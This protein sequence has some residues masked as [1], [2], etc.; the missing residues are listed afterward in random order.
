MPCRLGIRRAIRSPTRKRSPYEY[1]SQKQ[2]PYESQ[3]R[4]PYEYESQKW[5]P[6]EYE[7]RKQ[8]P[9]ESRRLIRSRTRRYSRT[10]PGRRCSVLRR[11]HP[12]RTLQAASQLP[13]APRAPSW[14]SSLLLLPPPRSQDRTP[15]QREYWYPESIYK[16]DLT[17]RGCRLRVASWVARD[18]GCG[19]DRRTALP[20]PSCRSFRVQEKRPSPR[21]RPSSGTPGSAKKKPPPSGRMYS[22]NGSPVRR[23]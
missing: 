22:S 3:K 17:A 18:P 12:F 20:R 6:Y 14:G 23:S 9:Y 1:E 2:N 4:N 5:N 16:G 7:S 8:N 19:R 15:E 11:R 13:Q 10:R 21:K